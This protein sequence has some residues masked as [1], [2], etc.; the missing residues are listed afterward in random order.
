MGAERGQS[1]PWTPELVERVTSERRRVLPLEAWEDRVLWR[2]RMLMRLERARRETDNGARDELDRRAITSVLHGYCR[3]L[4]SLDLERVPAFFTEDCEVVYG[5]DPRMQSHGAADL[6]RA[7]RRLGRFARTSHHLSNVEIELTGPDSATSVSYVLAWHQQPDGISRTLYAQ[8]HDRF[9]RTT[10]G[11]RIAERRQ[12][13]N[14]SDVPWDLPLSE[15]PRRG[16]A[17]L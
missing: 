11:W 12:L 16:G 9:V 4:D 2:D 17:D 15:A 7:L 13:T 3:M 6:E 1:D 5:P 8:Y 10:G 14:G